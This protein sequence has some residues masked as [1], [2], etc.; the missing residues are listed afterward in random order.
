MPVA[1][2][3]AVNFGISRQHAT[4]STGVGYTIL[5]SAG[6]VLVARTTSGVYET[7]SGAYAAL[8]TYPDSF[9]GSI[10][11]DTGTAFVTASVATEPYN[12]EANDPK[13]ADTWS[14]V[15]SITGS[16]SLMRDLTEGR[17]RIIGNQM[18]FY[19]SDNSTLVA[20]FN[21]FDSAG[22]PT[23]DAVFERRRV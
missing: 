6:S 23:M 3:Q 8:V 16:I 14:M 20:T 19:K 4:G 17:W 10:T 5:D 9:H 18:L 13:V 15:N 12:V 11:W 1:I 7:V 22:N 21:L 2:V